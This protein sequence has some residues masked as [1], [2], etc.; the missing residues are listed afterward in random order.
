MI[1]GWGKAVKI[2][3]T[4]FVLKRTSTAAPAPPPPPPQA[5]ASPSSKP[6]PPLPPGVNGNS[7]A[8]AAGSGSGSGSSSGS[9]A[10]VEVDSFIAQLTGASNDTNKKAKSDAAAP[11][12]KSAPPVE[13]GVSLSSVGVRNWDNTPVEIQVVVDDEIVT[14][15]D[16]DPRMHIRVPA[17]EKLKGVIDLMA[18]F[19]ASDGDVFEKVRWLCASMSVCSDLNVVCVCESV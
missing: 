14:M 5:S 19:V 1:L 9:G 15:K 3:P 6:P 17:D 4:P 13:V 16:S 18:K 7:G 11:P 12:P 10:E 2:N 8:G